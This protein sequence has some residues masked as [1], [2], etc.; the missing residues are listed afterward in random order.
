MDLIE[1]NAGSDGHEQMIAMKIIGCFFQKFDHV[2]WLHAQ[3][4][5]VHFVEYLFVCAHEVY[6]EFLI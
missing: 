2:L 3:H 5:F 1:L 4:H 6:I